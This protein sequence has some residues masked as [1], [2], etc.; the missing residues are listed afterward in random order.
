MKCPKCGFENV[1]HS[2]YCINCGSRVDGKVRCPKCGEFVE[3]T[4]EACPYCGFHLPHNSNSS[5]HGFNDKRDR[6]KKVFTKIFC[7]VSIVLFAL[8][9]LECW[10]FYLSFSS[11]DELNFWNG[12]AVYYLVLNIIDL[13]DYLSNTHPSAYII[14]ADIFS[15]AFCFIVVTANIVIVTLFSIKGLIKS[16]KGLKTHEFNVHRYLAIVLISNVLSM[17]FLSMFIHTHRYGT[18]YLSVEMAGSKSF[19]ISQL[20]INLIIMLISESFFEFKRNNKSQF[21]NRILLSFIFI[22]GLIL[23]ASFCSRFLS[24]ESAKDINYSYGLGYYFTYCLS[25]LVNPEL[26]DNIALLILCIAQLVLEII[27][28]TILAT[29]IILMIKNY[30]ANTYKKHSYYITM[31]SM[32]I[33]LLVTSIIALTVNIS[34][35]VLAAKSAENISVLSNYGIY[36]LAFVY[37]GFP[38]ATTHI[39]RKLK[40]NDKL[41]EQTTVIESK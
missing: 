7:I 28:I 1:E 8:G 36:A 15:V 39:I 2:N 4:S 18:T 10:G 40:R 26:S 29:S 20:V 38:F 31:Y 24:F 19:Y 27:M 6:I 13:V 37:A 23:F 22:F 41:A 32:T 9:I 25:Q 3:P 16:I 14:G 5:S 34:I 35:H 17:V 30:F 33:T 11:S 21:I 12:S